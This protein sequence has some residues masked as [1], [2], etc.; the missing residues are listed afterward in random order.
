[1]S[2]T[3]V[4]H[5]QAFAHELRIWED[6]G[7]LVCEVTDRGRIEDPLADRRRPRTDRPGG[8]GL[9]MA[10]QFCD[11]VQIRQLPDGN[12]VRLSMRRT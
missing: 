4:H 7:A 9:W 3:A 10:N 12:V 1:L 5:A 8:R 2:A 11:L 6:D